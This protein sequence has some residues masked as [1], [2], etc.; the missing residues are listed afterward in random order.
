[1]IR[2]TLHSRTHVHAKIRTSSFGSANGEDEI[3]SPDRKSDP[4]SKNLEPSSAY[5]FASIVPE[6]D[7]DE[8]ED[9]GY[10]EKNLNLQTVEI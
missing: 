10:D 2:F 8:D 4:Q 5:N 6:N 9:E 3:D 1:M 7:E